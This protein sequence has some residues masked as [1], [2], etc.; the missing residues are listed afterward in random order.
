M[1]PIERPQRSFRDKCLIII[2]RIEIARHDNT[3]QVLAITFTHLTKLLQYL[4]RSILSFIDVLLRLQITASEIDIG[5]Q[6]NTKAS[7]QFFPFSKYC[8]GKPSR[9]INISLRLPRHVASLN[10]LEICEDRT[11]LPHWV[12]CLILKPTYRRNLKAIYLT[13]RN[14]IGTNILITQF[15]N[16]DDY[17]VI[18]RKPN[19]Q[20]GIPKHFPRL[21]NF[22][23]LKF[24]TDSKIG[25][26]RWKP[27]HVPSR[28]D[29]IPRRASKDTQRKDCRENQPP[30]FL[31]AVPSSGLHGRPLPIL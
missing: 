23:R 15:L 19:R 13:L 24:L 5:L 6:M 4:R 21:T 17:A 12:T 7:D 11:L 2:I 31:H 28:N 20:N 14:Q 1:R 29:D 16:H 22:E 30:H 3:A 10:N 26:P 27:L 8:K 18:F 25:L 9:H